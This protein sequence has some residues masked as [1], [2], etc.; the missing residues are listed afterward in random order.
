M[1]KLTIFLCSISCAKLDGSVQQELK[2]ATAHVFC[3]VYGVKPPQVSVSL[4]DGSSP[5]WDL[6]V[7]YE[8]L[9]NVPDAMS[10]KLNRFRDA[11]ADELFRVFPAAL[12]YSGRVTVRNIERIAFSPSENCH[13]TATRRD[14][15]EASYEE[16]TQMFQAEV[17]R[18]TFDQLV[19]AD[20]VRERLLESISVLE[21][22]EKLFE[23][24][25]LKAIMSPSVLL[26]LYG[27]TGTGKSMTAEALATYVGK[28]IIRTTYADIESKYHGE[29]PKRLKA[30]FLAAKLQDAVL[31]IDEA[32]SMLS[33]RLTDVSD[34]SAQAI[35]SMRSQLLISLEN[36]EGI[37]IFATNLI[38]NYD[39]AFLSR[40][41][42][43][44]IKRPTREARRE[45]W[46]NHLFPKG[47]DEKTLR[48]PLTDDIDLECLSEY[49][50]CGRDIRNA[51][52]QAC[53]S[54]VL[55]KKERVDQEELLQASERILKELEEVKT[56]THRDRAEGKYAPMDPEEKSKL[57]DGVK[58]MGK[59]KD[60]TQG[61]S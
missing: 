39:K 8:E 32:D 56:A 58:K 13:K 37:V 15:D 2:N 19:L 28:K 1:F 49:D 50:F 35:N 60:E 14:D 52:K 45:I 10:A 48:I 51:V 34:G 44:E 40:L 16:M 42:C 23:E 20:S 9:P 53:I 31:F 36:Y 59:N 5:N 3:E 17:P 30:I 55:K 11:L 18:F 25:N 24:W 27:D 6:A 43:V 41:I 61:D 54:T 46:R 7:A 4:R 26:N 47:N 12:G 38:K 29:G 33:A 57:I 21:N 22:R